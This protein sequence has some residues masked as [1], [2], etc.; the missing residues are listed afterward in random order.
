MLYRCKSCLKRFKFPDT[1]LFCPYC[2]EV[3]A[4]NA[5]RKS[6]PPLPDAPAASDE[7]GKM[8]EEI[9]SLI[10]K[11]AGTGA[12]I[13]RAK[14]IAVLPEV[15]KTDYAN[16]FAAVMQCAGRKILLA[17]VGALLDDIRK[18][19]A[20]E[21]AADSGA[22]RSAAAAAVEEM[23]GTLAEAAEITGCEFHCGGLSV[24]SDEIRIVYPAVQLMSLYGAVLTAHEKYVRCVSEN[25]MFAAFPSDSGYGQIRRSKDYKK[26]LY[27]GEEGKPEESDPLPDF[28]EV[29]ASMEKANALRYEGSFDEDFLPHVNAFWYGLKWLAA[30][31]DARV[32]FKGDGFIGSV[33]RLLDC[34]NEIKLRTGGIPARDIGPVYEKMKLLHEKTEAELLLQ[35]GKIRGR[36]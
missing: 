30:F 4:E 13:A 6:Q 22:F 29:A 17:R 8:K 25:N 3:L 12:G 23:R 35:A 26:D 1:I 28:G 36:I 11:I 19:I 10:G 24:D 20:D 14:L 7:G 5:V 31:I 33:D 15:K 16:R 27:G 34:A 18:L 9:E 32:T 21:P 2:G